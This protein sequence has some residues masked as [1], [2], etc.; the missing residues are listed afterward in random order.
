[1]EIIW[2]P[3]KWHMEDEWNSLHEKLIFRIFLTYLLQNFKLPS[4]NVLDQSGRFSRRSF[5]QLN[6]GNVSWNFSHLSFQESYV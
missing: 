6:S 2:E 3:K 1:M 5:N 4:E